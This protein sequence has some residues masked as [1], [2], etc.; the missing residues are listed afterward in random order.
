M[1]GTIRLFKFSGIQV[2]LHFSW[3]LVAAYEFSRRA[4]IYESK[5]WAAGEYVALFGIVLLHEFGH[6]LACRQ[7]G[8]TADQIVLWPLGGIAFVNP[9]RRPGAMLWSIAAGPLVNVL[10]LPVLFIA[11]LLV[12]KD[13]DLILASD[14]SKFVQVVWSINLWLLIFNLLPVY[15]LDG[16]QIL[17]SLLWFPLG[18]IRSLQISSVIG[19]IGA[20]ILAAVAWLLHLAEPFWIVIL[21]F[22]LISRAIAG[23]QYAKALVQEEEANRQA[24]LISTVPPSERP[25]G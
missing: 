22:F 24:A 4:N 14:S 8:G 16:G 21:A 2:Y 5:V 13:V 15:P 23:W 10:L 9:P 12:V 19:L 17:R 1:G 20:V 11:W 25:T 18:E 6:A 3:F 7:T